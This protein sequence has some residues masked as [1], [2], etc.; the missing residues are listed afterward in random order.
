MFWGNWL[1]HFALWIPHKEYSEWDDG[2]KLQRVQQWNYGATQCQ[3]EVVAQHTTWVGWSLSQV[4]RVKNPILINPLQDK[5]V[6]DDIVEENNP[7]GEKDG[8]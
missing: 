7:K 1:Y 8:A 4:E 2:E 6:V 3:I 5:L